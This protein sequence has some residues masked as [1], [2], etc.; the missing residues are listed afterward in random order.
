MGG[1]LPHGTN[2]TS[3]GILMPSGNDQNDDRNNYHNKDQN[4]DQDNDSQDKNQDND[5]QENIMKIMLTHGN[6]NV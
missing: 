2:N 3:G 4:S 5:Y 6:R 1:F